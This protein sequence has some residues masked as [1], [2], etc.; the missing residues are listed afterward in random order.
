MRFSFSVF[1]WWHNSIRSNCVQLKCK[2]PIS[3][4][5]LNA[6]ELTLPCNDAVQLRVQL[7]AEAHS[8]ISSNVYLYPGCRCGNDVGKSRFIRNWLQICGCESIVAN[9]VWYNRPK[10]D[11]GECVHVLHN[12]TMQ[13]S[14]N[15][16]AVCVCLTWLRVHVVQ[17][18]EQDT[19]RI[20]DTLNRCIDLLPG[21][22]LQRVRSIGLSG[23]MHGVLLWKAKSGKT[24]CFHNV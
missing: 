10:R 19:G 3:Y 1:E 8:F 20:I 22:K 24:S 7:S 13:L 18:K 2:I 21:D 14:N 11:K 23:Q 17:A 5:Y 4:L 6:S 16:T 9:Y 12:F 15:N